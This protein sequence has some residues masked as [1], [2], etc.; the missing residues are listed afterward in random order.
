MK[1]NLI[2]NFIIV[3]LLSFVVGFFFSRALVS[4]SLGLMFIFAVYY[5]I[6]FDFRQ[7]KNAKTY[8]LGVAL[9]LFYILL[10]ALSTSSFQWQCFKETVINFSPLLFFSF[11]CLTFYPFLKKNKCFYY[12][13]IVFML[14]TLVLLIDSALFL[15][16]NQELAVRMVSESKNLPNFAKT[17]HNILG[18]LAVTWIILLFNNVKKNGKNL[19]SYLLIILFVFLIHFLALRFAILSFYLFLLLELIIIRI[20]FVYKLS[21]FVIGLI[22]MFTALNFIPTFKAR[23][24]NT[25]QDIKNIVYQK[26]PN[27]QSVNQRFIANEIGWDL[28]KEN[29]VLGVG[30]CNAREAVQDEY[31][32]DSRL[33]IPENRHF[34]HNQVTY[35]WVSFGILYLLGWLMLHSF[36]IFKGIKE[37]S[38]LLEFTLLFIFHQIV[39]NTL[40]KQLMLALFVYMILLMPIGLQ[41]LKVKSLK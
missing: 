35:G 40:E 34:I 13:N 9:F 3:L 26:N 28:I 27:Y 37:K 12:V 15:F 5:R 11:A 25:S 33:L 6:K 36:L 39:E 31:I 2:E 30:P 7:L 32:K 17:E 41:K 19:L 1:R 8:S 29:W 14:I 18:F 23:V 22:M 21:V 20:K 16:Y 10:V 24:I 4:I 38:L